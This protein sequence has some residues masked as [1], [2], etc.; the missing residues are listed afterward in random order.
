MKIL[1]KIFILFIIL[2]TGCSEDEGQ[3]TTSKHLTLFIVNDI[4][5]QLDNFLKMKH[6]IDLERQ[7]TNVLVV[8]GGDIFSGNPVVDNAVEKG[9]PMVDLMNRLQFDVSVMGNHEFDYGVDVL[10]HR[11]EQANFAWICANVNSSKTNMAQP[12]A[13][14]T[15][16]KGDVKVT[17]LGLVET[18]GETEW[19][20]SFGSSLENGRIDL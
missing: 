15:I 3:Q 10:K 16:T 12:D 7:E 2:L 11:V 20:H 6:V 14:K 4:H 5:G 13:Y 1:S 17:F 8:C 19:N 9:F 18:N